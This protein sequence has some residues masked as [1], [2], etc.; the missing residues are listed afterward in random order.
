MYWKVLYDERVWILKKTF[1]IW[2][3]RVLLLWL[4]LKT[5]VF[6]FLLCL[7]PL[8]QDVDLNL[9]QGHGFETRCHFL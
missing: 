9:S 5:G 7:P 3:L 1:I 4:V 8:S 2:C 6:C